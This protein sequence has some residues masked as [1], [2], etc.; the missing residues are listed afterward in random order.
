MMLFKAEFGSWVAWAQLKSGLTNTVIN[1]ARQLSR[2]LVGIYHWREIKLKRLG[3]RP[4]S[5]GRPGVRALKSGPDV[6]RFIHVSEI[7]EIILRFS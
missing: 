5:G 7:I 6:V 3:E 4:S 1:D 2:S